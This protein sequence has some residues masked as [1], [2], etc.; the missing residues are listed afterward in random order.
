MRK[1]AVFFGILGI[2]TLGFCFNSDSSEAPIT[3][4]DYSYTTEDE[5]DTIEVNYVAWAC[6][7]ANWLPVGVIDDD[8]NCIFI[9]SIDDKVL[10]KKFHENQYTI[11]LIGRFYRDKGISRDYKKPTSQKPDYAK[12]FQYMYYEIE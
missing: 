9:E 1:I 5:L 2:I 8:S 7:C 10:P 6:A 12:I 4:L 3:Y 11:K